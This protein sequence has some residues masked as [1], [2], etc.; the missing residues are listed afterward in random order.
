MPNARSG[1]DPTTK[2]THSMPTTP[3]A[4]MQ[5]QQ[6]PP[7]AYASTGASQQVLEQNGSS[8]NET[9]NRSAT[10]AKGVKTLDGESKVLESGKSNRSNVRQQL[11]KNRKMSSDIDQIVGL[12]LK[13]RRSIDASIETLCESLGS[14]VASMGYSVSNLKVSPPPVAGKYATCE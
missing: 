1:D 12:L 4:S 10:E 8:S 9:D 3:Q 2:N 14:S 5:P 13:R 6:R 7:P 11:G